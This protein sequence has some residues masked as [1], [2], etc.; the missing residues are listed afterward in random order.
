[1]NAFKTLKLAL[2]ASSAFALGTLALGATAS[3]QCNDDCA[4]A[5]DGE[6]DDGGPGSLYDICDLG[7]DCGDCGPRFCDD[8]CATAFDGECDDGGEGSLY[9]I[10]EWGTD[11]GDCGVR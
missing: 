3:A 7:S 6:C 4:T 11:C 5:F 2:V 8:S 9:D 1:M 10:C